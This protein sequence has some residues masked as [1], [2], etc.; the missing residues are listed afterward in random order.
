MPSLRPDDEHAE[1]RAGADRRHHAEMQLGGREAR[2]AEPIAALA[3]RAAAE[4]RARSDEWPRAGYAELRAHAE[5]LT[6]F[7]RAAMARELRIIELKQEVNELCV[8]QGVGARYTPGLPPAAPSAVP[9]VDVRQGLVPLESILRTEEL[10]RRP[11]R[12]PNYATENRALALLVQA[13]A[14]SPHTIA[15]V[16]AE[17]LLEVVRADSAGLS[18]LAR[19][20]QSFHWAAIAGAWRPHAGGGTPRDFGPCG[21]VLDRNTA[22]LFT[23]WERRYPYLREAT[24]LAEEGLLV[25]FY[26]RGRAVGTLWAIAHDE[27]RKFDTEDLRLLESLGRFASAAYQ[28]VESLSVLDQRRAALSL[29]E[30]ALRAQEALHRSEARLA[31]EL[32]DTRL[33]Q[34]ISA[35]LVQDEDIEALYQ[36]IMDAAVAIMRSDLA[37]MQML[38][39]ERGPGGELRLLA[40]RGFDPRAA[41]FWQSVRVDSASACGEALRTGRRVVVPDVEQC[42]FMAGTE[43]LAT[44][45]QAGIRAVQTTPL[46]SRAG[47]LVGMISTHWREPHEPSER[48]LRLLEILAR[49]AADL[50]ERRRA[51]A[52]VRRRSAQF[53][54][55]IDNT[56]L[57]ICLVDRDFRL[58]HV[59]PGARPVFGDGPDLIGRD[60]ADVS[61]VLWNREQ[62]DEIVRLFRHTLET[63]ES[64]ATC[65]NH[66]PRFGRAPSEH[67]EWRVDRIPLPEGGHGVVC[68][69]RDI[70]QSLRAQEA[71]HRSEEQLRR[72]I[73]DAPIPVVMLAEDGE[74]L[75]MSRTW[76]ALTGYVAPDISASPVLAAAYGAGGGELAEATHKLF[77]ADRGMPPTDFEITAPAGER[78]T[79]SFSTSRPGTL[80]DGRR[81]II[82]T[83]I[84]VTERNRAETVLK[85][86]DRRKDEFLATLS[87]EL[88]NPLAPIRQAAALLKAPG[89]R[90]RDAAW[91][92]DVIERHVAAMGW[93]LDDLLDVS[94]ISQGK[95]ELRRESIELATVVESAVETARPLIEARRHRLQIELPA[96]GLRLEA[97]PLRLAQ[98]ISNLLTNAAKYTDPQGR[99]RLR[100]RREGDELIIAVRDNGIGI[101]PEMLPR[102]FD[103]F[104]QAAPALE[105][106]EGGLGIGLA[107]VRGLTA[108]HGGRVEARSDGLGRGSEFILRL[109]LGAP[110]SAIPGWPAASPPEQAATGRKVLV[111]DDNRDSA[112]TLAA[113]LRIHGF[114]VRAAFN[115]REALEAA[116]TFQ[117]DVALLDIGMPELNGYEAAQHM[118]RHS[119]GRRATLVAVTGWGQEEDKRRAM[120]AGF[121]FHLRKPIDFDLLQS[122]LADD[123]GP[124]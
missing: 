82:G 1:K 103:M 39:P 65:G 81:F 33:L 58:R 74:V 10:A 2:I 89:L 42:A 91:A 59:N 108:L 7:N 50:I 11:K 66:H 3:P 25:P 77:A 123:R 70:S 9:R 72:A 87:H 116:E 17:T 21:D 110:A 55:L 54:A 84:D 47:E 6:R 85:E 102:V 12:A 118:R 111:V 94:R 76:S 24:P 75:E 117:P 30:D 114:E 62:A 22:L 43:D 90:E 4:E 44:C 61:R 71:L 122:L 49:Q 60:F 86:A 83:C 41:A 78:R 46:Y 99:I 120:A 80:R 37:S 19:D 100:A 106:T 113:L 45:L 93:L 105:R 112:E 119:W 23:R 18:L 48:D 16:L 57:G 34:E 32:A 109:P 96:P 5:E 63:G 20:Q 115:G 68:Y 8:R 40:F 56:P 15:Q 35:H 26:V 92:R 52:A 51:E 28:A 97:D 13:L 79:W 53:E 101:A 27:R 29:M 98:V 38:D 107:L 69:F 88:R 14:D 36:R 104:S 67:Y 73:E 95:I 31:A 121:D 64:H 124:V